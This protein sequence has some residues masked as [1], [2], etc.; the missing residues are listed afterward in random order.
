[1]KITKI[2]ELIKALEEAKELAQTDD[3]SEVFGAYVENQARENGVYIS[4]PVIFRED[5]D[6]P[7]LGV[8]IIATDVFKNL[9]TD[10]AP[11]RKGRSWE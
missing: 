9:F 3:L 10:D 5:N 6:D 4:D 11:S 1:M 7:S 8:R 2:S